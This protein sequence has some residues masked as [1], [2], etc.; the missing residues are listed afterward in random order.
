MEE[1]ED[2]EGVVTINSGDGVDEFIFY[3]GNFNVTTGDGDKKADFKSEASL[4]GFWSSGGW[5]SGSGND[6][7]NFSSDSALSGTLRTG[8]GDDTI[9][10]DG[11]LSYASNIHA[12]SGNDV[13]NLT[14]NAE[15]PGWW[16]HYIY[17]EDGDDILT[18]SS[19]STNSQGDFYFYG[20]NGDDVIDLS[21]RTISARTNGYGGDGD[22]NLIGNDEGYDYLYGENGND[23]I[24]AGNGDN[25]VDG[26]SGNDYLESGNGADQLY[27]GDD[28]DIFKA[29]GGND[30]IY[31]NNGNSRKGDDGSIG[32]VFS[33]SSTDYKLSRA[34]D[35]NF[36]YVYYI[37]DK[38][39]GSP[40]GLDTLYDID[41]LRFN[42]GDFDLNS[43][44]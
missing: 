35:T 44:L 5:S 40:D 27:G 7:I 11:K 18:F 43:C 29:G 26:G 39:D 4:S 28:D 1:G 32:V 33:G 30:V 25:T 15:D 42:D 16:G 8:G 34:T 9:N 41:L 24:Y 12:G 19:K 13:I 23:T 37:Q 2:V 17:G 22:D 36:D 3:D 6:V 10:V 14:D 21:S 38:R 20:G 31:G